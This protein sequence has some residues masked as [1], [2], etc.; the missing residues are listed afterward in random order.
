MT[1]PTPQSPATGTTVSGVHPTLSV[2]MSVGEYV[3]A[4]GLQLGFA[5]WR[6]EDDG[7]LT[8]VEAEMVP[9]TDGTTTYAVGWALAHAAEYRWRARAVLNGAFGP[10]SNV[11]TFRT[12]APP[13]PPPPPGPPV[14]SDPQARYR[15]V[16]ES[17]WSPATHPQDYPDNAHYSPL[18]GAT[19]LA[20]TTFWQGGMLASTGIERMA[21]EGSQS[22]LDAEMAAAIASGVAEF[23]FRGG[24]LAPTPGVEAVEFDVTTAFP[25]VTLVSMIAPSPDWFVGVNGLPLIANGQWRDEVIVPL[26]PWDAGTD[27]GATYDSAD[28]DAAPAT[29]VSPLLGPPVAVNG[30]VA[31]FGRFIFRRLN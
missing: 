25:Y 8:L 26:F 6:M 4:P 13:P 20:T 28:A 19:H 16:F 17:D 21:E 22:P 5:V 12:P 3:Q 14:P 18:I 15:A 27:N 2:A 29:P 11:A 7:S 23:L 10:W 9:Q 30:T 24:G 31:P 1:S